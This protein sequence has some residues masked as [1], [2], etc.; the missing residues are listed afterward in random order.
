MRRLPAVCLLLALLPTARAGDPAAP[1]AVLTLD[2]GAGHIGPITALTFSRDGKRLLTAGE[3]RTVRVW[4][5]ADI[6]R[7][8]AE[9][10]DDLKPVRVLRPPLW[11]LNGGLIDDL[12]LSPDGR[13]LA[14]GG[15]GLPE[16]TGEAKSWGR[17]AYLLDLVSG[18]IVVLDGP[19]YRV[20]RVSFSADGDRLAVCGLE[21]DARDAAGR[22]WV[23]KGLTGLWD[24][25]PAEDKLTAWKTFAAPKLAVN[26]LALSPDGDRLAVGE[27][28][29]ARLLLC[30]L[31]GGAV[32]QRP[33]ALSGGLDGL[34]WDPDGKTLVTMHA[35]GREHTEAVLVSW[36][37]E[38]GKSQA[39]VSAADWAALGKDYAGAAA[40]HGSFLTF[41]GG[42]QLLA[43]VGLFA[44]GRTR[45]AV[46]RV[47]L[48][49][50]RPTLTQ[51]SL[52]PPAPEYLTSPAAA[53]AGLLAHRAEG[54][55][56]FRLLDVTAARPEARLVG[57][58]R[59]SR[60]IGWGKDGTVLCWDGRHADSDPPRWHR[61]DL[62]TLQRH[63]GA[64]PADV[65]RGGDAARPR[66]E[67]DGWAAEPVRDE[68][69]FHVLRDGKEVQA[70]PYD[71]ARA[72]ALAGTGQEK[73]LAW[74]GPKGLRLVDTRSG[75]DGG[76][77]HPA[78]TLFYD[79]AASPDGA[80]LLAASDRETFHV[81]KPGVKKPLL[82]VF[83]HR[84]QWVVW[85]EEGYYAAS[86][87]GESL[88]GWTVDSGRDRL[89]AFY[90]AERFRAVLR[91]PDVIQL[92]L[93][94]GDVAA[95]VKAADAGQA[96]PAAANPDV[97]LPPA[98]TL[99]LVD[100]GPPAV[101]VRVKAVQGCPQQPVKSL[102]LLIDGRLPPPGVGS[103]TFDPGGE[104]AS[105][106]ETWE[107]ELPPGHHQLSVLAR[108]KDDTPSVS[109][110][111]V[112]GAPPADRDRPVV[113]HVAVGVKEYR[114]PNLLLGCADSD[115][116][117][118]ADA[119]RR[120]C[121]GP[122]NRY[123]AAQSRPLLNRDATRQAVLDAI[124]DVRRTSRPNDLFILSFSGHGVRADGEF[125]LLTWE[126]DPT[127]G[128]TL[129]ETALSGAVLRRELTHFP[130]QVL[131]L[132]DACHS[133]AFGR[134]GAADEAARSLADV[135]VR[136]AVMCAALGHEEALERGG[137]GLFT[138]AVVR[139]LEH[140][141]GVFFDPD[142]G[143]LNVYHLQ[144]FVYQE[145]A[146]ASEYKQ[147]PYLKMPLALPPF[148]VA[149]FARSP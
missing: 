38:S 11:G 41:R 66:V 101:K 146:K 55:H 48:G 51:L 57:A 99:T 37:A 119:V 28:G 71:R 10:L 46:V 34:A 107:V 124:A 128:K 110:T 90:P 77:F 13:T 18:R 88:I 35:A 137:K 87:D 17:F 83:V 84:H 44:D 106:E 126:A 56:D 125:Y 72:W 53:A 104:K 67:A 43:V 118:L 63:P 73:Y 8:P 135:D 91:R 147:T 133:G 127:S 134:G 109:N 142:T 130:C 92:V 9:Q 70:V 7:R 65:R 115:A 148:V 50:P 95:A 93:Q 32:R 2:T 69:T 129:S 145:V 108:S 89:A 23:W 42:R 80:Y 45:L 6:L 5:T 52:T 75:K 139:A 68:N 102:R 20:E 141:R 149:R 86:P 27:R 3:D 82:N 113:R 14:V 12:T 19:R 100:S 78:D 143:E 21:G 25:P 122:G 114:D 111:L 132:L 29:G 22:V 24:R 105:V 15:H 85:T 58:H 81:Y 60:D 138:A 1:R 39:L 94:K 26:V 112:V 33:L 98:V 54:R 144:A 140:D 136:V 123:R 36:S 76:L 116:R 47:D 62:T 120:C 121:A 131:L 64:T 97:L 31:S 103:V 16:A 96:A 74:G 49:G 40:A 59:S 79:V 61:L 117:A 4:D 30:D